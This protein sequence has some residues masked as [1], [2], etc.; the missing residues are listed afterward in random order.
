MGEDVINAISFF[1]SIGSLLR[2]TNATIIALVPN[3][4]PSK[5]ADYRPISCCNTVYKCISKLMADRIKKVL[6]EWGRLKQLLW[7]LEDW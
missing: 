1:F 6:P 4:N 3:T 2:E 5:V 7:G